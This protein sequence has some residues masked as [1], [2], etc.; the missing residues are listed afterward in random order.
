MS[1]QPATN[2]QL[3]HSIR[4]ITY[5]KYQ[6]KQQLPRHTETI[7]EA[8]SVNALPEWSSRT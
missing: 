7:T 2:D 5:Y 8:S 1:Y 6:K 4:V 3:I